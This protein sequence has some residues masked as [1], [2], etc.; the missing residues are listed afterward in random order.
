M[1][2]SETEVVN[3]AL[4]M[5][6]AGSITSLSSSEDSNEWRVAN[7]LYDQT[8]DALLHAHNWNF[9]TMRVALAQLATDPVDLDG[10]YTHQFQLPQDPFCLYVVGT[11]LLPDQPYEI[12]TLKTATSQYRVLLCNESTVTIKYIARV[13][14]PT[15]WSAL[16]TVALV[17]RLAALFAYPLT[18]NAQLTAQLWEISNRSWPVAKSRDGQEGRNLKRWES[19]A[20]TSGR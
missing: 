12:E 10:D 11:D 5:V 20:F 17:D 9:A 1:A 7:R 13:T 3:M 4:T 18:R 19:D 15:L 2:S 8:L 6:G 16:F 14:D